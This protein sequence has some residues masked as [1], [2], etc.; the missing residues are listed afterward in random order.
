MIT[1]IDFA[2]IDQE[3]VESLEETFDFIKN[4]CADYNYILF[5]ADGEYKDEYKNS[6]VNLNPFTIDNREDRYKDQSRLNFF[7]EFM[8][9]FY[10]FPI[11][12]TQT[13]DDEFRLTMELMVYTHIWESKPFLKQLFRLASLVAGQSY[14]WEVV[15]PE[16][17]KHNYIRE[18]IR[19]SFKSKGLKLATV[20]SKGFHTSLR[21]AFAHSEYQFNDYDKSINLDTY[22]GGAWDISKISYNDWTKRFAYSALLSYH[23]L[24]IK[25]F[26]R[27]SLPKEF[28][29]NEYLIIHPI[30]R[31]RFRTAKIYYE[32][33][34]DRFSFQ[35]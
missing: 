13:D 24:N 4:H 29:K 19:N 25:A 22:K 5:L 2:Q 10:S 8:K 7:I 26:K 32:E 16:L 17:R 28:G 6:H 14:Q 35:K 9:T 18:E 23:F 1:R 34:L 12:N 20:I 33:E 21:N 27:K 15:V 11:S 31:N 3:V 30:T